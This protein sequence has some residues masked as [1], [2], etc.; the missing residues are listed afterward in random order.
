MQYARM[1]QRGMA[2][3]LAT[4]GVLC[5]GGVAA[6]QD[7]AEEY[8]FEALELFN[9]GRYIDALENFDKAIAIRPE[10]VYHCNR[11][12]VLLQLKRTRE[13]LDSMHTCRDG[14]QTDD[15]LELAQI[16]A[17]VL[18]LD[19]AVTRVVPG[20]ET[21][22]TT[23]ATTP[24][25]DERP[26]EVVF[27]DPGAAG[28]SGLEI[29]AW[30]TAGV[31][32]LSL[33]GGL[34]VDIATLPLLDEYKSA[35]ADGQDRGQYDALKRAIDQRRLVVGA[36]VIVGVTTLATSGVLFWL[37]EPDE[38]P[39]ADVSVMDGGAVLHLSVPF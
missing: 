5:W 3:V 2:A 8:Y 27:V 25:R 26:R 15:P 36:L 23:I 30:S 29:A 17:E 12:A 39:Q 33:V 18:A 28:P 1:W 14:F 4:L 11:A 19:L 22:A 31:G 6:A 10:P 37:D 38:L 20:S 9:E 16:D 21:L 7:A 34:V 24:V 32:A 35:G 13:A